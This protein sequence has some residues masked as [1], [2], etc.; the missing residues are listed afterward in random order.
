MTIHCA[1]MYFD[2]ETETVGY[3]LGS[4]SR[5]VA[6]IFVG[7]KPVGNGR[8]FR[9]DK[10][11][12]GENSV[13]FFRGRLLSETDDPEGTFSRDVKTLDNVFEDIGEGADYSHVPVLSQ[14]EKYV[15]LV[16]KRVEESV[17]LYTVSNLRE[18]NPH[19]AEQLH[20]ITPDFFETE[21]ESLVWFAPHSKDYM[22]AGIEKRLKPERAQKLIMGLLTDPIV[23]NFSGA[24]YEPGPPIIYKIGPDGITQLNGVKVPDGP[25]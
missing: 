2:P 3:L 25:H 10:S 12:G 7:D 9:V 15:L 8:V 22:V 23:A 4:D 20:R 19:T 17:E 14:A 11:F 18:E 24:D 13:G 16:G 21:R 6:R 5:G 1:V